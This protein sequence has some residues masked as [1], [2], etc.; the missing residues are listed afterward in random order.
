[1]NF[2]ELTGTS[3]FDAQIKEPDKRTTA[4]AFVDETACADVDAVRSPIT[5]IVPVLLFT[6]PE[7]AAPPVT[8]PTVVTH[9]VEALVTPGDDV[10]FPPITFPVIV[11]DPKLLLFTAN[12]LVHVAPVQLPLII[13]APVLVLLTPNALLPRPPGDTLPVR[14]RVPVPALIIPLAEFIAA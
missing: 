8:F 10:L 7:L 12:E 2:G 9:P 14:V 13:K 4:L 6:I 11:T 5:V 1:M 3:P